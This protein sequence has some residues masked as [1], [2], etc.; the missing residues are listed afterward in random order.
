MNLKYFPFDKHICQIDFMQTPRL[1]VNVTTG[2]YIHYVRE[3]IVF[4]K[5]AI[6][7]N[8]QFLVENGEW[9]LESLKLDTNPRITNT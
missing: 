2:N 7:T 1:G 6:E 9:E 3:G 5:A 4:Q 8:V